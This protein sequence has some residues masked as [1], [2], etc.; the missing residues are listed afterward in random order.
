MNSKIYVAGLGLISAIGNN[1][2]ECL[3]ALEN[4]R[5]GM[6]DIIYLKTMHAGKIPV[7]EVKLSNA[8]LAEISGLSPKLSRTILLSFIAAREALQDAAIE[9]INALRTGFI[10]A[11]TV[12][13]IDKTENY[14]SAVFENN[15]EGNLR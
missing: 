15:T 3:A 9:D 2:E 1:V 5:A 10:S 6:N 11:N 8:Q 7:A 14:F 13:G 4:E 12:G